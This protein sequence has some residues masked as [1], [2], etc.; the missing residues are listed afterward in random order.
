[1]GDWA[2]RDGRWLHLPDVATPITPSDYDPNAT[3]VDLPVVAPVGRVDFHGA[4]D[5][6]WPPDGEDAQ[7]AVPPRVDDW[8]EDRTHDEL[9]DQDWLD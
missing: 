8:C 2:W 9:S 7:V 5:W 4:V 6:A 1:M 3:R